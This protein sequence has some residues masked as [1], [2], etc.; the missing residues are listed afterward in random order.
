MR[1]PAALVQLITSLFG[2]SLLILFGGQVFISVVK[3]VFFIFYDYYYVF[4]TNMLS[5]NMNPKYEPLYHLETLVCLNQFFLMG[6]VFVGKIQN[7]IQ[8]DN[9]LVNY[10]GI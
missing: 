2:S 7:A 8:T 6:Y 9:F 4:A 10:I 5:Q 3:T 1:R